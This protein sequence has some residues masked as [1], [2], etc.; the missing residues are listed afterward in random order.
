LSFGTEPLEVRVGAVVVESRS[1]PHYR[2]PSCEKSFLDP[3][4]R[5]LLSI[6]AAI[7]ALTEGDPDR[8]AAV[9]ARALLEYSPEELGR[10]LEL[11]AATISAIESG[12]QPIT[13]QYMLALAALLGCDERRLRGLPH[14]GPKIARVCSP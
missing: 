13:A 10:R 7:I 5:R 14:G 9:F 11:G 6:Q 1:F 4:A 12:E 8:E 3:E 2:C